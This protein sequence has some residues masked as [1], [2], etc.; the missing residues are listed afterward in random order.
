MLIM[1]RKRYEEELEKARREI[2]DTI[3]SKQ[4][5]ERMWGEIFRLRDR[6]AKLEGEQPREVDNLGAVHE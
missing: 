5:K 2:E 6:V 3:Y 1:T 4:E